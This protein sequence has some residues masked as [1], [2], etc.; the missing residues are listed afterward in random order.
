MNVELLDPRCLQPNPWNSNRVSPENMAKLKHSITELGFA[1]AIVVRQVGRAL[2]ILG[3]Q[4]R[5]Q[6]AIELGIDRVPVVNVGEISDAQA[7]K[8]GLVDNHR[9]G[10]DDTLALAKIFEDLGTDE[11]DLVSILPVGRADIEAIMGMSDL[12]LDSIGLSPDEDERPPEET[13]TSRPAKTHEVMKFRLTM[14]NAEAIRELV[15]KA[16]KKHKLQDQ[17][18]MTAAGDALA[19]LL[20]SAADD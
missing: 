17:D 12:D 10:N 4:H 13:P 15:M 11:T 20:L 18:E 16:I 1:G 14:A 2:Q 8:I 3:G 6:A 9:Y 19:L 7:K 5:T